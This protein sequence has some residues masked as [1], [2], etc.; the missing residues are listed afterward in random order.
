VVRGFSLCTKPF[1]AQAVDFCSSNVHVGTGALT[2]AAERSSAEFADLRSAGQVWA[3][4]PTWPVAVPIRCGSS[5]ASSARHTRRIITSVDL[6]RA[7]ADWPFFNPISRADLEVMIDVMYWPPI[8]SVTSA[9][10][11]LIRTSSIRPTN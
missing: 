11:P 9:I 3:P 5:A 1:G 4:A 2:R 6:I 8:D 10:S 7:A